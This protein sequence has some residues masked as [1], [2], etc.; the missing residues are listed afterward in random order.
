MNKCI[1]VAMALLA[2]TACKQTSSNR[3][4]TRWTESE[5]NEWYSAQ[6]WCAGCNYVPSNKVNQIDMWQEESYDHEI[7]D[8][9]LGWAQEIGFNVIRVFLHDMAYY[10]D[11]EGFKA[12]LD[13]F[14]SIC[15]SHG[16]KAIITFF[17]NGGQQ[18]NR[19]LGKQ[20]EAIPG[21]HNKLWAR[22][23]G[24]DWARNPERNDSLKNYVQDVI[25]TFAQDDRIFCWYLYNEPWNVSIYQVN[26]DRHVD[27]YPLLTAVFRWAREC[28]PTQP[29]TACMYEN[30]SPSNAF[31]GENAD[32]LTFH[33]YKDSTDVNEWLRKLEFYHRP[34]MCG[35]YMGRPSSTFQ[36]IMPILKRH[37]VVAV[38][39]GL[40][41]GKPGYFWPWGSP[42]IGPNDK[43]YPDVWF[44][45][46]F[47]P[48]GKPYSEEEIALI[49]SL[50]NRQ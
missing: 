30:F 24:F 31:I 29:L 16:Q 38:N 1:Y 18:Y 48:D 34:I 19:R 42:A 2:M 12:R 17:T 25:S 49:K 22:T 32:I 46:I 13:D 45:D 14:L 10:A 5:I 43:Q 28:G 23:P 15:Q 26:D 9:E 44:H 37:N 50:T 6:G 20:P 47:W 40:V 21:T 4:Y 27:P 39:F 8:K 35:E 33:S 41:A 11:K 3:H 36:E 7:M